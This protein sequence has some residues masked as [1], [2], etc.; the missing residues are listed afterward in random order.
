MC[1]RCI[2][3]FSRSIRCRPL[4]LARGEEGGRRRRAG[5][6][7]AREKPYKVQRR[8]QDFVIRVS[9]F[10]DKVL[11]SD[12]SLMPRPRGAGKA[13]EERMRSISLSIYALNKAFASGFSYSTSH[14]RWCLKGH[15]S[16]PIT[17]PLAALLSGGP[18]KRPVRRLDFCFLC[19]LEQGRAKNKLQTASH[20]SLVRL[21][22][23]TS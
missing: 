11:V 16:I 7:A 23:G 8:D 9:D 21:L 19:G 22:R 6:A 1:P 4:S 2:D 13:R 12:E 10:D 15:P 20:W 18:T 14:A 17:R 3:R 5:G